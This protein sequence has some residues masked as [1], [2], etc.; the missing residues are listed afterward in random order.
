[1]TTN[2]GIETEEPVSWSWMSTDSIRTA[3]KDVSAMLRRNEAEHA[4]LLALKQ[5]YEGLLANREE[6]A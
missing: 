2:T 1:M 4:A 6:D 3:L 5:G